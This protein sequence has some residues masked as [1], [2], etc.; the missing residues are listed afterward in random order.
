MALHCTLLTDLAGV[1]LARSG[2]FEEEQ[3]PQVPPFFP[4]CPH[5]WQFLQA[6]QFF[7]PTQVAISLEIFGVAGFK[8]VRSEI[9]R[10]V[11]K[12]LIECGSG[13]YYFIIITFT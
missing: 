2:A 13:L 12:T 3:I 1:D 5:E 7:A 10:H 11:S 4:Q 8:Y 9:S 6:E